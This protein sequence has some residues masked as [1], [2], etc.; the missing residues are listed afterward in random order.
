M[1][2]EHLKDNR[3]HNIIT[4]SQA[5]GA[6]YERQKLWKEKTFRE[7]PFSGN[8]MTQYGNDNEEKCFVS[9]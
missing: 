7:P 4:A 2:S 9:I 8:I 6:V 1:T 3:R 5:W